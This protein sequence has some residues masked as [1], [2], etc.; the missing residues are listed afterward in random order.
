VPPPFIFFI[1]QLFERLRRKTS[2]SQLGGKKFNSVPTKGFSEEIRQLILCVD[3]VKLNHP[4]LN[5]LFDEM[6]SDV[7]VLR[8][9]VL[10]IIAA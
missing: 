8:P 6:I 4:I 5:L 3:E 2:H 10:D 7:D 1:H 9:R